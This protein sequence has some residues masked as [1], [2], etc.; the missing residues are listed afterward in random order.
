MI[1]I[2]FPTFFGL[3][4][5]QRIKKMDLFEYIYYYIVINFLSNSFSL[6]LFVILNY[7]VKELIIFNLTY[8]AISFVFVMIFTYI[9]SLFSNKFKIEIKKVK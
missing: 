5:L 3:F 7:K 6:F 2:F 1:N 8:V 9:L 4:L